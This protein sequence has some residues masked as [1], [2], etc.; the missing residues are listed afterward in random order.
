MARDERSGEGQFVERRSAMGRRLMHLL[1]EVIETLLPALVIV[2]GINV[3]VARATSIESQSMEP[4]LY[5]AQRLIIEKISFRLHP[6]RRGDIIVFRQPNYG[7]KPLI[8][9]VVG[10][11]GEV[12]ECREGRVYVDGQPLAEPYLHVSTAP[13]GPYD[14]VPEQM[15][16]V[17]GDNRGNSNDSR[18]FGF[19]PYSAILGRAWFRYWPLSL[20]GPLR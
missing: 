18:A 9:R 5:E 16:F 15:L 4:T 1:R 12:I 2:L 7:T 3:F 11:P 17:M 14:R 6:P 13:S 10:L 19:V 8:K 20:M